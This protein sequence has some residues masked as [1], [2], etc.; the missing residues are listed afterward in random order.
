VSPTKG[1]LADPYMLGLLT[2][3]RKH[4]ED[5]LGWL[6]PS[7]ILAVLRIDGGVHSLVRVASDPCG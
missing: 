1:T 7:S 5:V 2:P 3:W 6:A 4:R